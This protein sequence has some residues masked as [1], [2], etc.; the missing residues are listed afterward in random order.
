MLSNKKIIGVLLIIV[1]ILALI[2]PLTPGSWL[3]FVGLELFGV[4]ILFWDKIKAYFKKHICYNISMKG[5]NIN[6]E[7][8]TLSNNNFRRVLY[9][10]KH[11][12]LV[13]MCLQPNEDIGMEVHTD[14]DQFFRF[15]KGEGK[16]VIDGHE[17]EIGDGS[18]IVVPAGAKH[19]ITNTSTTEPLKLY[20]IY[21]P[22]HHEDGIV[23]ATKAE[24]EADSPEFDGVTT[25]N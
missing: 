10:G 19:N 23:R 8:E 9:T 3:I 7:K 16:C 6:I 13:L 25:E 18:V 12:Q 21:S 4:R 22:A 2:T 5:F 11:S 17:Y 20:T 1:G 24:A 14:N 15:E